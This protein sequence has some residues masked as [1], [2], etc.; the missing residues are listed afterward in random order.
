METQFS[1]LTEQD[2]LFDKLYLFNLLNKTNFN[3][4]YEAKNSTYFRTIEI[5]E[6]M[7]PRQLHYLTEKIENLL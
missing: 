2:K 1:K 4:Y 6:S 3:T 7:N 5:I